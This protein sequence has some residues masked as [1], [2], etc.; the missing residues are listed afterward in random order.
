ML[1]VNAAIYC[2][3]GLLGGPA[4]TTRVHESVISRRGAGGAVLAAVGA[5]L[6][7]F[8]AIAEVAEA[9]L[10]GGLVEVSKLGAQAKQLREAARTQGP[11]AADALA[12]GLDTTLLPLQNKMLALAPDGSDART[13]AQLIQGHLLEFKQALAQADFKEYVSKRTKQ[14]YPGGKVERE[15]EEVSDTFDDFMRLMGVPPA[16]AAEPVAAWTGRYSD[17]N[18]PRGYREVSLKGNA[19]TIVGRDEPEGPKWTLS[20]T[21][22]GASA[23]IDFSPKGGPPNLEATLQPNGIRFPDGNLWTKMS[24]WSGRY[25]DPSHPTGYRDVTVRGNA[26]V[27]EGRDEPTADAWKLSATIDGTS[28]LID[29]SPKGGPKDLLAKLQGSKIT[30]PDGNAWTKME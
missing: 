14:T 5:S 29:F 30:F 2:A 10:T 26:L 27:I 25:S 23:K 1:A 9:K 13:Q 6:L 20:A 22:N 28:A 24:P 11:R 17:P 3:L 21:A 8:G 18:H 12:R 15:L 7:P 4:P 16:S 19:L